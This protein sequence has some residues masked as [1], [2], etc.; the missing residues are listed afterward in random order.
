MHESDV[1]PNDY[2]DDDDN[3]ERFQK[4][5]SVHTHPWQ[6]P[7]LMQSV[8]GADRTVTAV[9]GQEGAACKQS[10]FKWAFDSFLWLIDGKE[11]FF[12]IIGMR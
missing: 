7:L 10:S 5:N 6:S 4:L 11:F 9:V 3:E 12:S 8:L 2:D 1:S